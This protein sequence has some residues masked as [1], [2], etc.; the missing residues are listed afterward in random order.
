M[1]IGIVVNDRATERAGY[2][3]TRLALTAT[4][5]GHEVWLMGAGDLAY[6][7]DESV[8]ARARAVPKVEY[9]TPDAYLSDLRGKAARQERIRVDDL[10]ILLLRSNPAQ[11]PEER[12]WARSAGID[13]GRVAMRRG[14]IVLNDPNALAS[15]QS[16]TYLQLFP[17]EVR[18]RTLVSKDREELKSFVS[19]LG[20]RAILKPLGGSG[21]TRVFVVHPGNRGNTNQ[22]IEALA[23]DGYVIAQEYLEQEPEGDT[24]VFLMNGHPLRSKRRY[25][26]FRRLRAAGGA[27]GFQHRDH[28]LARAELSPAQLRV[29]DILR[30]KLVQDGIFLAA[31]D[32]VGDFLIDIN[33]FSPGGLG[34]AQD[35]EKTNF[36]VPVIEALERKVKYMGFYQRNF[37]NVEMAT[38]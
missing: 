20:G 33:L 18:A 1:K 37:G 19:E 23:R 22:M 21:G 32:L 25:A 6:D 17:E 13:F 4:A 26:A 3:T 16:K 9:R 2:T 11:E 12:A 31:I 14:V 28:T 27:G 15:A 29:V 35:L 8:H 38:L 5:R 30:P 36:C 24:R 10:D 34:S 7:A